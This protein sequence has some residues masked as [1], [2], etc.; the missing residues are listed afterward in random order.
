MKVYTKTGDTGKT[1]LL[2]GSRVLKSDLQIEAYGTV[3][4]LNSNI[5]LVRDL[6]LDMEVKE[7][8]IKIQ[9]KL[10]TIGA[11]LANDQKKAKIKLPSLTIEAIE[12]LEQSIDKMEENLEPL[13][14]FI[15]PGGHPTVSHTHIS[16]SVCRRAERCIIRFNDTSENVNP[17]VIQ[18]L[19]RLSDYLFVLGRKLTAD[20]N[21]EEIILE[22]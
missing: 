16:R 5:G 2:G 14:K 15:L 9:N 6:V 3:D 21:G 8:L 11:H 17:L 1:S 19:N 7:V 22:Y 12:L 10:F 4:E 20:L 13:T 18:Y